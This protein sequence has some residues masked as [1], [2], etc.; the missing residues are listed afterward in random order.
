[1]PSVKHYS[2]S[3]RSKI[4]NAVKRGA[5]ITDLAERH[6]I[7]RVSIHTW[8]RD[9]EEYLSLKAKGLIQP[10]VSRH[11]AAIKAENRKLMNRISELEAEGMI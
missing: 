6:G 5:S 8:V 3:E 7:T 9:H 2:A 4:V 11:L 10:A 1:M